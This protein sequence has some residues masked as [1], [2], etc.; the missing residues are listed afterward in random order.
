MSLAYLSPSELLMT[1]PN[2]NL[3]HKLDK[4]AW[5]AKMAEMSAY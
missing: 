5:R 3:R 1:P 2:K 4:L